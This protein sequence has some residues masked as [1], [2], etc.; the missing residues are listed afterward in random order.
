MLLLDSHKVKGDVMHYDVLYLP[1][2]EHG[3]QMHT[4]D[5]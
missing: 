3:L 5:A 2:K 4:G 1:L